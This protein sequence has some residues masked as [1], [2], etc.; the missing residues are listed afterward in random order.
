MEVYD[1]M[2]EVQDDIIKVWGECFYLK[3]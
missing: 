3:S 1:D 2:V